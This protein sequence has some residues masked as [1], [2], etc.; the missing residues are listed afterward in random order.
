M[1]TR[2]IAFMLLMSLLLP[3]CKKGDNGKMEHVQHERMEGEA[4][5]NPMVEKLD[6]IENF[7]IR[8]TLQKVVNDSLIFHERGTA[9]H[10]VFEFVEA[11]QTEQI[12]GSITLGDEYI[13]LPD[14]KRHSIKM[15]INLTELSGKWFYDMEQ[16]RGLKIESNGAISS[17]NTED[18]SFRE[19]KLLNERFYIYYLTP[20]MVS[21]DRHEYLVEPAN[22]LSLDKSHLT[23]HFLGRTYECQRRQ[24]LI[25][26]KF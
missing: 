10:K 1:K 4:E 15:A 6:N 25:K 13:I 26:M 21:P 7:A 20:D 17:I 18:I 19:W 9:E 3:A 16:H 24:E 14:L 2:S 5:I 23:F 22:I 11:D 8:V 12:K